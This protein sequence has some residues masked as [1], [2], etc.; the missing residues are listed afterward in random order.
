[1]ALLDDES[2]MRQD[3]TEAIGWTDYQMHLFGATSFADEEE[4]ADLETVRA[5]LAPAEAPLRVSVYR[6]QNRDHCTRASS[7]LQEVGIRFEVRGTALS[8]ANTG[9]PTARLTEWQIFVRREDAQA[10]QT[11]L[12]HD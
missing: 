9:I 2:A 1:M 5:I 12:G 4:G 10:A 7:Q 3:P 8:R 11:A 6:T